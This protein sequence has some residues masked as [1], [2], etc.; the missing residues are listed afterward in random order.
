M[1]SRE[2][3]QNEEAGQTASLPQESGQH[4]NA[5]PRGYLPGLAL[6]LVRHRVARQVTMTGAGAARLKTG[7]HFHGEFRTS[8]SLSVSHRVFLETFRN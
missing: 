3:F 1:P 2:P 8:V 4:T 7:H 6:V 5:D